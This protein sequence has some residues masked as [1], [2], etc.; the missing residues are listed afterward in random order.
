[1]TRE[2]FAKDASGKKPAAVDEEA[3]LGVEERRQFVQLRDQLA[4]ALVATAPPTPRR[5]VRTNT[6]T[7]EHEEG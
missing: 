7:H 5:S 2:D 4:G 6:H 1:L 3:G